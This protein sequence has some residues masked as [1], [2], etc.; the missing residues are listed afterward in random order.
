[1]AAEIK[2]QNIFEIFPKGVGGVSTKRISLW[3]L[4]AYQNEKECRTK[5]ENVFFCQQTSMLNNEE[6][7]EHIATKCAN[8]H[9]EQIK[10]NSSKTKRM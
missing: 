9:K 6:M 7:S 10:R 5:K 2:I 3:K 4:R 1:M 8:C